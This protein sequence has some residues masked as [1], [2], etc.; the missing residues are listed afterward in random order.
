M[1]YSSHLVSLLE[2]LLAMLPKESGLECSDH[3]LSKP[4]ALLNLQR[5][6]L[7]LILFFQIHILF[8]CHGLKLVSGKHSLDILLDDFEVLRTS[9]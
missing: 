3:H 8:S 4:T 6:V 1:L 9:R 5:S 2:A 7:S